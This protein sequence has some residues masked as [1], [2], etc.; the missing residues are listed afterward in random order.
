RRDQPRRRLLRFRRQQLLYGRQPGGGW[1]LDTRNV[2]TDIR[3]HCCWPR[4]GVERMSSGLRIAIVGAGPAGI[5]AADA[6]TAERSDVTVDLIER[7]PTPLGLLRYGVAPDHV[8]MKSL[9]MG[10]QRVL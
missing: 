5:Y 8:K 9:E 6:L 3:A 1:R 7:L 2:Q 10:M 4:R